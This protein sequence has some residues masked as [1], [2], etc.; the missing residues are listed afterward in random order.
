MKLSKTLL[1][2]FALLMIGALAFGDEDAGRVISF[3]NIYQLT[4]DTSVLKQRETLQWNPGSTSLRLA[5]FTEAWKYGNFVAEYRVQYNSLDSSKE[6]PTDLL[7]TTKDSVILIW[8]S[9]STLG[10]PPT[11]VCSAIVATA[12]LV[13]LT[14][15]CDTC[16]SGRGRI[17]MPA[18]S[19]NKDLWLK[20][21]YACQDSDKSFTPTN[22]RGIWFKV[23]Y[24]LYAR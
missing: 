18:D 10:G 17:K 8:Y 11:H 12:G 5:N 4:V 13:S 14:D 19:I 16:K 6:G 15:T 22:T 1:P 21:V 20:I 23:R 7:D 24:N 3:S 2:L 9:T